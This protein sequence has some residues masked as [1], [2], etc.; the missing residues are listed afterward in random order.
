MKHEISLVT[1]H[2]ITE[3]P[4]PGSAPSCSPQ[5]QTCPGPAGCCGVSDSWLWACSTLRW[6]VGSAEPGQRRPQ[7]AEFHEGGNL[8]GWSYVRRRSEETRGGRGEAAPWLLICR[9]VLPDRKQNILSDL[10]KLWL[11]KNFQ[12][13]H[14]YSDVSGPTFCDLLNLL[15]QSLPDLHYLLHFLCV[16]SA[17]FISVLRMQDRN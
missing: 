8:D 11:C 16:L 3:S 9:R 5:Y 15:H 14:D 4:L 6:R 1:V 10:S 12:I 7:P 2:H 17:R 13:N